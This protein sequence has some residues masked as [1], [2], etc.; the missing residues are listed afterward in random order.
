MFYKRFLDIV[1]STNANST[2]KIVN[3]ELYTPLAFDSE[4]FI[5]EYEP[6]YLLN[7]KTF[8]SLV[9]NI[10]S[11]FFELLLAS[12]RSSSFDALNLESLNLSRFFEQALKGYVQDGIDASKLIILG[13]HS[14]ELEEALVH[15]AL[16]I[17]YVEYFPIAELQNIC[18]ILPMDTKIGSLIIQ[19]TKRKRYGIVIYEEY[20]KKLISFPD[21]L[22]QKAVE[23]ILKRDKR[24]D[25]E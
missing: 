25:F 7:I 17:T 10:D 8:T 23:E 16:K 4:K 19:G 3:S 24:G 15:L 9:R 21:S 22:L 20:L 12:R 18:L 6:N 2:I 5:I 1:R 11:L 13:N 14:P